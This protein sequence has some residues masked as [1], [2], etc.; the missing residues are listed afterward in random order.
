MK[1]VRSLYP[2]E[3]TPGLISLLAG[4]PNAQTFP[5]RSFSFTAKSPVEDDQDVTLTLDQGDLAEGLQYS[6]TAGLP[7]LLDWLKGLQEHQHGRRKDEGWD[8]TVGSG[9]QDLI[10]KVNSFLSY[11]LLLTSAQAIIAMVNPG[12]S[13]LVES[14]VYS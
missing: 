6:A 11:R 3:D 9:S 12:D 4:K 1:L 8:I 5:F 13:V 7:R 14:P 2:L 10:Y